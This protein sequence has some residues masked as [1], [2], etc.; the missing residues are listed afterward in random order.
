M[1]K[2][3]KEKIAV[4]QAEQM[5]L[6]AKKQQLQSQYNSKE[7]KITDRRKYVIGALVLKEIE[8]N[9]TLR[10]YV[11]KLLSN[12]PERDKNAFPYLVLVAASTREN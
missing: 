2:N 12:A 1:S 9:A 8:I 6:K 3:L 4:L 10:N 11:A 7:R 5:Q